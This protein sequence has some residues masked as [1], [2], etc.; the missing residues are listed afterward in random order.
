MFRSIVNSLM[1]LSSFIY[2]QDCLLQ[3]PNDPL[4]TGL[5]KPWFL[6]TNPISQLPCS[7]AIIGSEVFVEATI[8]DITN[9]SF[10]VYNPLVIDMG[11][12]PAIPINV[13]ALP[14]NNI[15]V[16]HIWRFRV[17]IIIIKS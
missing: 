9:N 17:L 16:I 3:V 5:F 7:Q 4:N 8:F 11:T 15:V 14:Q 13:G 12:V 2:S 10:F 1:L 6:S